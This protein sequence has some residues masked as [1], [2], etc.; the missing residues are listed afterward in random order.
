[1]L[2]FVK[3]VGRSLFVGIFIVHDTEVLIHGNAESSQG[4]IHIVERFA[5][6]SIF[7]P[8][9][10]EVSCRKLADIH[11]PARTERNSYK[12]AGFE[13]HRGHLHRSDRKRI[14]DKTLTV[15]DLEVESV[16]FALSERYVGD[17][18]V[19]DNFHFV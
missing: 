10:T 11:I 8:S 14:I 4:I 18:T 19:I 13:E 12:L 1:M 16:Q 5:A 7:M 17:R 3:C 9:A 15:A 2:F 6:G